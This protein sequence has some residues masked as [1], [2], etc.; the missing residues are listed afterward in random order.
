MDGWRSRAEQTCQLCCGRID[1]EGSK[2]P[3]VSLLLPSLIMSLS[4]T[5]RVQGLLLLPS[6]KGAVAPEF[7]VNEKFP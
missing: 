6:A 1:S 5:P 7:Y 3:C 4:V 2:S